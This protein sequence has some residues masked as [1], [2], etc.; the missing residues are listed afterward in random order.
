MYLGH[1]R[2]AFFPT[3]SGGVTVLYAM[4][5]VCSVAWQGRLGYTLQHNYTRLT[6]LTSYTK[7]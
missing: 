3:V 4:L 5:T 6:T 1:L 2:G 7:Y